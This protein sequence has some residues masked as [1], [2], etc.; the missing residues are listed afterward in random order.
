[1]ACVVWQFLIAWIAAVTASCIAIVNA[2]W[3]DSWSRRQE[4]PSHSRFQ[5]HL[6]RQVRATLTCVV[7]HGV[8]RTFCHLGTF[9]T[10]HCV[11]AVSRSCAFKRNAATTC[12]VS[13]VSLG[14]RNDD[15]VTQAIKMAFIVPFIHQCQLV[16]YN[17]YNMPMGA[18]KSKK[19]GAPQQDIERICLP[20]ASHLCPTIHVYRH[21]SSGVFER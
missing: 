14:Q 1:M 3:V 12:G 16:N 19:S 11:R 4:G 7:G 21:A 5:H 9:L 17:K 8:L 20:R 18:H 2:V 15:T 10:I 6:P 13:N